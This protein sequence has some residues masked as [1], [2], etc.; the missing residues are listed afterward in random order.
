VGRWRRVWRGLPAWD[1]R[2]DR[3]VALK[4]LPAEP[5]SDSEIESSIIREGR[6]LAKVRH[7]NVI[8]IYGAEQI[9]DRV[10]I[11]MEFVRGQTLEQLLQ[12][13]TVVSAPEALNIGVDLCRAVSAVHAAGVLHRDIKAHITSRAP[14]T[15]EWS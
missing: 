7:P 1:I 10:G 9:G 14:R 4:L 8:T 11:W 15:A 2:L 12:R 3:E 6:L 13:G 5:S